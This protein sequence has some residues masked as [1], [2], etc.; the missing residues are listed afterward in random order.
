MCD[1]YIGIYI[2]H[3]TILFSI[4]SIRPTSFDSQFSRDENVYIC[5]FSFLRF[6]RR[7]DNDVHFIVFTNQTKH[8]KKKFRKKKVDVYFFLLIAQISQ[9]SSRVLIRRYIQCS[10]KNNI[11]VVKK[12]FLNTRSNNSI[13]SSDVTDTETC[14][15]FKVHV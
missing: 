12:V 14:Y 3:S 13:Y 9:M 1:V 6:L 8:T 5:N 4:S 11:H 2:E 10:V 15:N 7:K